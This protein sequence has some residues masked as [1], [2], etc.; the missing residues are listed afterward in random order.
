VGIGEAS[1][2]EIDALNILQATLLAMRR[3]CLQLR[4]R[5]AAV[6]VDGNQDPGLDIPTRL[7]VGG[8]RLSLSIAA[9]SIVA[10]VTRDR[11]MCS[12][13]QQYPHYG[14]ETNAGY[15]TLAHRKGLRL[16][17]VTPQHRRSFAPIRALLC[18]SE[19]Q[20]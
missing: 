2:T 19:T 15:G 8:D 7:V 11:K 5:P 10:K 3:A 4:L 16:F 14:W 12:L 6:L 9:A 13:A 1:V 18:D 20:T 17:G